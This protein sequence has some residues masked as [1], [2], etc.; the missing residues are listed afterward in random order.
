MIF[1]AV[2]A[3]AAGLDLYMGPQQ[4]SSPE[5][6][7]S[8]QKRCRINNTFRRTERQELPPKAELVCTGDSPASKWQETTATRQGIPKASK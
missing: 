8:L 3:G 4:P 7:A 6:R 2:K 5:L 1:S